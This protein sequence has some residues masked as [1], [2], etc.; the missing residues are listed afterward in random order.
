M[1]ENPAH[2]ADISQKKNKKNPKDCYIAETYG[3][4]F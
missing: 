3:G 2:G 4:C 1:N